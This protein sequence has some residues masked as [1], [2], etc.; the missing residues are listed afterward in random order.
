[1]T[2]SRRNITITVNSSA[3][4]LPPDTYTDNIDFYNTTNNQGNSSRLATLIV[5]PKDYKLAVSA[6][7]SADGTVS[8]GGTFV[9]GSSQTVTATAK[10]GH[11]FVHW[12]ENGKVVTT[13]PSYTFTMPSANVTLVADFR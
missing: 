6:S 9:E 13:S 8:G 2:T 12:T 5:N 11:S 7:P 4:N 3:R 10:S 1:M